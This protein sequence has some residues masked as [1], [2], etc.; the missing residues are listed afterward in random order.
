MKSTPG[1][2]ATGHDYKNAFET[3]LARLNCG[4][5]EQ[6]A[7]FPPHVQTLLDET[8]YVLRRWNIGGK[9]FSHTTIPV[10]RIA[11][12]AILLGAAAIAILEKEE[13]KLRWM[14]SL[15]P[16]GFDAFIKGARWEEVLRL[17][18]YLQSQPKPRPQRST[19][20]K[21]RAKKRALDRTR[22]YR[23]RRPGI[24]RNSVHPQR[25]G[26]AR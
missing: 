2:E 21:K 12:A 4:V 20:A 5:T 8:A 6:Q 18:H 25:R 16:E 13:E 3:V 10:S 1:K 11:R 9:S 23:Q 14:K 22:N 26:P 24:D 15:N 19:H 17:G 7:P